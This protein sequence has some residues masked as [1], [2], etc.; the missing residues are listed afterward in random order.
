MR[1][2]Y[3]LCQRILFTSAENPSRQHPRW[4]RRS[5]LSWS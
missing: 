4:G 2:Q 1:A 5:Y 3:R